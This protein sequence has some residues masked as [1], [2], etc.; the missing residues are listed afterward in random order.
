MEWRVKGWDGK[1]VIPGDVKKICKA[2]GFLF[3]VSI[4]SE[5]LFARV[6]G[7]EVSVMVYNVPA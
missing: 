2:L 4:P 6:K 1:T 3:F 7:K 5:V